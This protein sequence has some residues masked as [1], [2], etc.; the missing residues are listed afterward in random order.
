MLEYINEMSLVELVKQNL[1]DDDMIEVE[2]CDHKILAY[3]TFLVVEFCDHS[4]Y[5]SLIHILKF[6]I[7]KHVNLLNILIKT[8]G[9]QYELRITIN[10]LI[11]SRS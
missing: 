9:V 11:S 8:Y 2:F 1:L 7:G 5:K 6:E 4:Y 3:E 10:Y